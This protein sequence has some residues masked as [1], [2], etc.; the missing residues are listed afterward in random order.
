MPRRGSGPGIRRL[1][2]ML[3]LALA[4]CVLAQGAGAAMVAGVNVADSYVLDG[5][6]LQLNGAGVRTLTIFE[7]KVYVA[8]LYVA[9]PSHDAHAVEAAPGSKVLVLTFLRGGSKAQVEHEYREGE[10]I[11]CGGGGCSPT[12]GPDFDRLVA[13]APAV[14]TGDTSTYVFTS[15]GVRVLAN[16]VVLGDFP[17]P[18]FAFRLLDGFL[19]ARPPSHGLKAALLGLPG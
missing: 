14:R 13:M 19:G 2:A 12:D 18:D 17:N 16:N 6:T 8:A 5:T 10:R 4:G 7:V 3:G 1:G 15:K 9:Q 11:N